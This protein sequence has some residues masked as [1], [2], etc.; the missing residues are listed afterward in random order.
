MASA[1]QC[2]GVSMP[3][4]VE[5]E[6]SKLVLNGL[7]IREATVLQVDVYVAGLYLPAKTSDGGKAASDDVAKRLVLKFVREVSAADVAKAWSEGFEKNA[8]AGKKAFDDRIKKL[9]GWMS[10]L[11]V[12]DQAIFTYLPGK[13]I[14]VSVKGK[15]KGIVEGVDFMKVFYS[16]WLGKSPPNPGLK[17]GLLGGKCG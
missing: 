11:K 10:D 6:G 12:G 1:A 13:G 17:S 2:E 16:I 8:G 3:D 15:V 7:G 5:V 4:T 14:E 9:N